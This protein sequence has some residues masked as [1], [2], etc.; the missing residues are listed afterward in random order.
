MNSHELAGLVYE[1][2]Q[3][4]NPA[5]L[6]TDEEHERDN[7]RA[8]EIVK[9]LGEADVDAVFERYGMYGQKIVH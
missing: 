7:L 9:R 4:T 3:V 6:K 1:L 2:R 5:K 8:K